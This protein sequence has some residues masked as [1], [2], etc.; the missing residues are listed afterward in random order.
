MLLLV[1]IQRNSQGQSNSVPT[2]QLLIIPYGYNPEYYLT[3]RTIIFGRAVK[4]APTGVAQG[5][6][7]IG[8]AAYLVKLYLYYRGNAYGGLGVG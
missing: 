2:S 1:W 5:L 4:Y 3:G 7:Y 6:V 8:N